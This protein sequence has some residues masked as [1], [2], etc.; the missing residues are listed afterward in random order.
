M[1]VNEYM[2]R[3]AEAL[4]LILAQQVEQTKL[5][6]SILDALGRGTTVVDIKV[7]AE[8]AETLKEMASSGNAVKNAAAETQ[9]RPAADAAATAGGSATQDSEPAPGAKTASTEPKASDKPK[10]V[11]VDDARA[12]LKKYAS[13]EG[14][15]AAM[16]LLTGLGASSITALAEQGPDKLAKLIAKCEGRDD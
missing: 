4:E 15:D 5:L 10:K 9:S 8:M 13:A 7:P 14:N 6:G 16:E 2:G 1:D 3:T 12:A 11:T